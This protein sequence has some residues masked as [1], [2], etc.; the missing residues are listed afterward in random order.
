MDVGTVGEI[1]VQVG[2]G[3]SW[4]QGGRWTWTGAGSSTTVTRRFDQISCPLGVTL[5]PSRIRA[6][7]VF[8]NSGGKVRIDD[9]RAE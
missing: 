3:M 7:W 2:D 6:V 8:L 1:A 4:C 9:I 5:G